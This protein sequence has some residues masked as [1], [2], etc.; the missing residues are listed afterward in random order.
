MSPLLSPRVLYLLFLS[1]FV[2][3]SLSSLP[4]LIVLAT[5]SCARRFS[6][7]PQVPS[8][9][10]NVL[11]PPAVFVFV[12]FFFHVPFSGALLP[13]VLSVLTFRLPHRDALS[14]LHYYLQLR[15]NV[16][17]YQQPLSEEAAFLLA[18]HALQ[19]DLGDYSEDQHHGHYFDPALYFPSW[20]SCTSTAPLPAP[21]AGE[22]LYHRRQH[23]CKM[24]GDLLVVF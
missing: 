18:S 2:L 17:H 22:L 14:R 7:S 9:I 4:T 21:P 16:L 23:Q 20:V 11:Q 8:L 3:T 5:R 12:Y 6:T 1:S 19:A 24:T 15:E 13:P 10:F